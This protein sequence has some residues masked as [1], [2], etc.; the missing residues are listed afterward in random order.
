MAVASQK[1]IHHRGGRR[2]GGARNISARMPRGFRDLFQRNLRCAVGEEKAVDFLER[3]RELR[4][5]EAAEQRCI[6]DGEDQGPVTR[7]EFFGG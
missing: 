7:P 2:S 3:V 1:S 5:T 4:L 6:D